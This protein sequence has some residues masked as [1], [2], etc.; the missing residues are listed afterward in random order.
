M[1]LQYVKIPLR[2]LKVH[3]QLIPLHTKLKPDKMYNHFV[4]SDVQSPE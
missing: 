1:Y 2:K 3:G 4:F